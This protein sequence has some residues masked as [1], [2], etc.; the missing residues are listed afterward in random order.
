MQSANNQ[1][2]TSAQSAELFR[3]IVENIKDYAIFMTDA[4]GRVI[5]WNPGV[6]SLLGYTEEEILGQPVSIIFT[7][8]DVADGAHIKEMETAKR[9]GCAEDKRWHHRKDGSRFWG[10][11]MVMPLKN[12]DGSLRGFAKVMRDDTAQKLTEENLEQVLSSITDSFFRFDR[13]FRYTYVNRATTEMFGISE[14]EY[15]GKTLGEVFP[16]VAGNIFHSEVER[17]LREQETVVFENFYEPLNRWFEN[18]AYPTAD[19]LSV[20]TSEITERKRVETALRKS[21]EKY[22]MLFDSIDEGFCV[23]EML[24]DENDKPFDYRFLEINPAFEKQTGLVNAVGKTVSELLN[25]HEEFWFETYGK[26]AVTGEAARFEHRAGALDRWFDVYAFQIGSPQEKQVAVLFNNITTRKRRELNLGFLADLQKDFA[27]FL[28]VDDLL[29]SAGKRIVEHLDLS[30]CMFVEIDKDADK[31]TVFYDHCAEGLPN[32]AG[33]YCLA[34]FHTEEERRLLSAGK[35]IIINDVRDSPRSAEAAAAFEALGI[36]ALVNASYLSGGRWKFALSAQSQTPKQWRADEVELLVALAARIYMRLER[37]RSEESL[38]ESEARFRALQQATPDGFMIFESVRDESG[39]IKDFRWVYINP[40]ATRIVKRSESDLLGKL[41][42]E[43]MP[44]NRSEGLFDEYVRVVETGAVW[45]NEFGYRHENLD[46]QFLTT[47]VRVGDGFAVGFSDVTERKNVEEKIRESEEN[48]RDLANS[49]SQWAWMA[50]ATGSI[51]WYNNRWFDYTGTTLETMQGWGWQTVHHPDELERVTEKFKAHIASGEIWEDTFP[52]RSKTGEYRWFLSRALPIRN[53]QGEIVRWFGTNTDVEELRQA[54]L[55]AEQ[56][57]RLKDEFLATLSHELRTPLNAILG[58]SQMLQSRK[59]SESESAKALSTIER[60]ARAQTQLIDDLL[61]V[62]RIITGKLRLNVRAVDLSS[63][64]TA[65]ADAA[66]PAAEAKGIRLQILLD[67]QAEPISGDPDRLQQIV[68]NMLSNS[69]KFTPKG[70]R[71]QVRLERINSH[72]EIVISDTGKGIEKEFLPHVFDR[73]RQSDGSMTRRHG[74]LGLGLAIVRQLVEL[75]GGQVSVSS[76]GDGQ[77][78]TFTVSLPVLPVR[79]EPESKVAR[80]HPAAQNS[81]SDDLPTD[82]AGLRILLVDDEADSRELLSVVLE[83]CQAKVTTAE[84]AA[85]AL[86]KFKETAFDILISDI[87]MPEE[88]GFS[89]VGK[90]RELSNE[91]GGDIPAIALTA[92]ARAEDR[93]QALRS[94]F[95]MHLA[96]PVESSELIAAVANL[97]GR[98]RNLNRS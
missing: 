56:A 2:E 42:C 34:D 61:D 10:N 13:N 59:V 79:R 57:N 11:G 18:R 94:G 19:G 36:G 24:F 12:T 80:V 5:S 31:V 76:E 54:Q 70:G 77:G 82:L 32:L 69:V 81:F 39:V 51:S 15:L 40:A 68:W 91:V 48:F 65:A 1:S 6:G 98:M 7:P 8:E 95:Q 63:V 45:Q 28:S 58:W 66:R 29:R 62:S 92:Y 78:A 75:H 90:I 88:D 38:L 25:N 86:E 52:L 14:A 20:F 73:F 96:K 47:A 55:Q 4:D 26:I 23:I 43:E 46:H 35:A 53:E 87:G 93:V 30:H 84:S 67:P 27:D 41:L 44:G 50:D 85:E 33:V 83:S 74:G 16:D 17:A 71:V 21:E 9:T 89:L 49:I 64:I 3:L 60:N 97:T 37:A 22:R 72:V